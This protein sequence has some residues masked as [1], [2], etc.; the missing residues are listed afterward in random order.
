LQNMV[1][2][3]TKTVQSMT[4]AS[5]ENVGRLKQIE[6]QIVSVTQ[7]EDVR[8]LRSKLENCLIEI[9]Q[10][11][12]RQRLHTAQ[13]NAEA[14]QGN[15]NLKG[16]V[17]GTQRPSPEDPV[18]GLP[19]RA[20]AEKALAGA[21]ATERPAYVAVLAVDRIQ[22]YNVNF[23]FEVGDQVLL[24]FAEFV[25]GK[26]RAGE[27]VFRWTGPA[28]AVL[29]SRPNRIETVRHEIGVMMEHKFEHTVRTPTRTIHLPIATRWTVLPMMATP[30]LLI[31]KIDGFVSQLSPEDF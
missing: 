9:R 26:L 6:E 24:T 15:V 31:H 22:T 18:T 27:E 29:V 21:I 17:H 4:A 13:H 3:L 14:V 2:M 20:A 28:L 10:E 16:A 8:V 23:G 11:T 12:E 25:R 30:R 7:I 1:G 19:G 5:E